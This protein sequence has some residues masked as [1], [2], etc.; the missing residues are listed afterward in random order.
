M[1]GGAQSHL[2][3]CADGNYYV[4][5]LQNKPQHPRALANDWLGTRLAQTIGLSVP[6]PAI[7]HVDRWLIEHT[8]DLRI[9][10]CGKRI[11]AAA[12]MSFG[13]R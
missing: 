1:R 8:P 13:S 4:I 6:E 11:V 2:M 12:G 3:R 5:K 10:L 7:V 9:E